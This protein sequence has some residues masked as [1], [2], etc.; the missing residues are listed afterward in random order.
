MW[1]ASAAFRPVVSSEAGGLVRSGS[2]VSKVAFERW[3]CDRCVDEGGAIAAPHLTLH[4]NM[5][6]ISMGSP[7][8]IENA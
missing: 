4:H 2:V 6:I 7:P 1:A 5:I 3:Y 8:T